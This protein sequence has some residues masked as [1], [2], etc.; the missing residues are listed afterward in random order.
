MYAPDLGCLMIRY[1][2]QWG[3]I[4]I[5]KMNDDRH[6][7]YLEIPIQIY[8]LLAWGQ[9]GYALLTQCPFK[10]NVGG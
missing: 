5:C 2:S 9:P 6:I 7:E 8:K 1:Q 4:S 3:I 10:V